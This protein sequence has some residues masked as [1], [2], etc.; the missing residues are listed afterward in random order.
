[1]SI[2]QVGTVSEMPSSDSRRTVPV[3]GNIGPTREHYDVLPIPDFGIDDAD[4]WMLAPR[5][6]PA[7]MTVPM[8]EPMPAPHPEPTPEPMPEPSPGPDPGPSPTEPGLGGQEHSRSLG[9]LLRATRAL[10]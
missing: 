7:R 3:M 4:L 5:S 9:R 2:R 10:R 6:A 8:P 1:V